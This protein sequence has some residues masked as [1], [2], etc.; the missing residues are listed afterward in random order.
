MVA[1]FIGGPW[2]GR[3][4]HIEE[5]SRDIVVPVLNE[6]EAGE[7]VM[8]DPATFPPSYTEHRYRLERQ[9]AGVGFYQYR[10]EG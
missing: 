10:G 8:D 3:H 1:Q 6:S 7:W 2:D 5:L 9:Y 4:R